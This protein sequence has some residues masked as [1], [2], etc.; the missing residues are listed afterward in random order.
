MMMTMTNTTMMKTVSFTYL[1]VV[2]L[3]LYAIYPLTFVYN[4]HIPRDW[5]IR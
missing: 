4:L 2:A 1:F 3:K 5:L